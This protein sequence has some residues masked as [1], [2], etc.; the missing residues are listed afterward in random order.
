M[1]ADCTPDL[2]GFAAVEGAKLSPA[3]VEAQS[4]LRWNRCETYSLRCNLLAQQRMEMPYSLSMSAAEPPPVALSQ[5]LFVTAGT[6]GSVF[7]K[8]ELRNGN[9]PLA[10][11]NQYADRLECR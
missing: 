11:A 7:S 3:L 2:S 9:P 8:S 10:L 1:Q 4:A 6:D 5:S